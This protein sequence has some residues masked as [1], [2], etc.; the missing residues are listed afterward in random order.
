MS[1]RDDFARHS[2]AVTRTKR[3]AVLRQQILERDGWA[4]QRCGKRALRL[5]VD[6]VKPVRLRPDLAFDPRNLQSLCGPCHTRK[7]RIEC[8]H[9]EKSPERKAWADAVAELATETATREKE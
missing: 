3:W 2:K 5:E 7:T 6:H 9:K 4:C 8:G 1:K